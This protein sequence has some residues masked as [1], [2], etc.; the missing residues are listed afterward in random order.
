MAAR[1]AEHPRLR[2]QLARLVAVIQRRDQ[3]AARQVAR[4]AEDDEIE[5]VDSDGAGDHARTDSRYGARRRA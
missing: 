4:G 2:R 5:G 3:L 1:D